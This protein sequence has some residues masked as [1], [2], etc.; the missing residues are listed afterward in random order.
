MGDRKIRDEMQ[1]MKEIGQIDGLVGSQNVGFIIDLHN[2]NLRDKMIK[3]GDNEMS[4]MN[5]YYLPLFT[6]TVLQGR[7]KY[8][9]RT[10]LI[11]KLWKNQ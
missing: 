6:Q 5:R 1:R 7:K 8:E 10:V 9:S 3:S 11:D 4:E 2:K